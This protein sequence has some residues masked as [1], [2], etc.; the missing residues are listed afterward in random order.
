MA[1]PEHERFDEAHIAVE[2]GRGGQ[3]EAWRWR[4]AGGEGGRRGRYVKNFKY[5]RGGQQPKRLWLPAKA[6]ARGADGGGV[7]IE[8]DSRYDDLLHLHGR[9]AYRAR[10]GSNASP[11]AA[12]AGAP[13]SSRPRRRGDPSLVIPVPV[14]TVVRA[15]TNRRAGDLAEL[16]APGDRV[17]V[18]P[19]GQGGLGVEEPSPSGRDGD[20]FGAARSGDWRADANGGPGTRVSLHLLL[21]VVADIGL[22]G[23]P[24]AGKSTLLSTLT[25][26]KPEIAPYPFTTLTPNLGVIAA[27]SSGSSGGGGGLG[28][29]EDAPPPSWEGSADWTDDRTEGWEDEGEGLGE[30]AG[31]E[32]GG[33]GWDSGEE[34]SAFAPSGAGLDRAVIAD[35]PGLISDAHRGKGLGRMFLR[36][37]RRARLVC[38]LVD[39]TS[40][41]PLGD[42][43]AIRDELRMYNPE[44][45]RSKPHVVVLTKADLIGDWEEGEE[46]REGR[47]AKG[48]A[49]RLA[50]LVAA[51]QAGRGGWEG[52]E[53]LHAEP[54]A[55]LVASSKTGEGIDALVHVLSQ[56]LQSL[57]F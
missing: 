56:E 38:H 16:L 21:R 18:A 20:G 4:D 53:G 54:K 45:V 43:A 15:A 39:A 51:F 37:L 5:K 48:R 52:A 44:Y 9:Y 1:K 33:N 40:A 3:G 34:A 27:G 42:Y 6:P 41:D 50:D 31:T 24:N 11:A 12:S 7:Y 30:G 23:L 35:L 26:A 55:V 36:H 28:G 57:S 46:G 25:A 2:G 49:G 17:L 19:G 13:M 22:V 10:D 14:G 32:A 8:A 29:V 47:E